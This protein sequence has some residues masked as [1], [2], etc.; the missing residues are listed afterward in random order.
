MLLILKLII[1]FPHS[2]L[3]STVITLKITGRKCVKICLND[4]A[5]LCFYWDVTVCETFI[6]NIFTVITG[7][8]LMFYKVFQKETKLF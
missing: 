3:P 1:C 8:F 7:D 5:F 6:L 2:L 4:E